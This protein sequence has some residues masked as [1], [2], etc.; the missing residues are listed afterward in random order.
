MGNF[1]LSAHA[2]A[3]SSEF[4]AMPV[5]R[6]LKSRDKKFRLLFA[7]HPQPMWILD[8]D[9]RQFLEVNA[10][11][12]NLYGYS[13]AEFSSMT[14]ADV[15]NGE[16]A[17]RFLAELRSPARPAASEWR[18]RAKSGRWIEV[19]IALHPIQYG[20]HGAEL[21]VLM[22]ITSRRQLEDQL[23]QA[24]KMEALGLLTGGVA[25][26]FNNLLTIIT[27]YSQLILGKL[28]ES[29]PNRH[30]AQQIVKAAER[31][32]ELTTRLLDFS[33]RRAMQAKV[34][35][36]NQVVTG[37]GTMLQR[38]IGEDIE[39]RLDLAADLGNVYA[40]AGRMEQVL[41]NLAANSR[42]AMSRGGSLTIRTANLT[43]EGSPGA[44]V[45]PGAYVVL[46]VEDTGA[47]M[48]GA[49]RAQAFEPFF[50]TKS[51]GQGTGLGLYTVAGIVKQSGGTVE[52]SSQPGRGAS[53]RIYLPRVTRAAVT[54]EPEALKDTAVRGAETILLVEDDDMLRT[55][56]RETM[57]S[58]GYRILEA[59]DPL[60]ACAI[61]AKR[62]GTIQLLIADVVLP[63]ASGPELA[64][65]LLRHSPGLKVLYMSGHSDSAILKRG[66]R[67]KEAAFLRKP[68]TP[69]ALAAKVRE[70]L[71]GGGRTNHAVK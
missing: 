27:G 5:K 23:R 36:L 17:H 68:F 10:A 43:V 7:E 50:T 44:A 13:P 58:A 70:V 25:H 39:L 28:A 47:G 61:A 46:T 1:A 31:A 38:L 11:A 32:G 21:A 12:C 66:V 67:R 49:T 60:E 48:D 55:L 20:G 35:D 45:K 9:S 65:E 41:L 62:Q 57:E 29:D 64:K 69:A 51:A 3:S 54:V 37:L 8:P 26:D 52:L 18:H 30:S 22:D 53:L 63:G 15:Q 59:C 6:L 24:Q 2:I 4:R 42:D 34:L 16:D 71:E 40:D 19:E 33:R 56:V 14:L